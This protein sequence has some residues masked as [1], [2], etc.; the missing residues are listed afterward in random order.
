VQKKSKFKVPS[1]AHHKARNTDVVFLR[2]ADGK[3]WQVYLG[4]HGSNQAR[5]RYHEV[6]AS[7]LD[8]EE[9]ETA[10]RSS[11][12]KQAPSAYPTVK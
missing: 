12:P 3:R 4:P 2:G 5:Q 10:K 7:H 9:P 11:Q 6:I 8:G 1:I